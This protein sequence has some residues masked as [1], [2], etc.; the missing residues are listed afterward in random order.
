MGPSPPTDLPASRFGQGDGLPYHP[1]T[2]IVIA[3]RRMNEWGAWNR[4]VVVR[5]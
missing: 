1:A 5:G 4:Q 3:M 2:F